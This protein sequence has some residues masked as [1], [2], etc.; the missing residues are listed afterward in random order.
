MPRMTVPAG[1]SSPRSGI[2]N[3]PNDGP[4]VLDRRLDEVHRGRSDEGGD[5]D[6]LRAVVE[7]LRRVDL[8]EKAVAHDG[9]PLAERH[10]LDL[11]VRHVHRRHVEPL[12]QPGQLGP[13]PDPQLGV[14][15]G[16]RL[17]HQECGR[18]AHDRAPHRH[19][20]ALP[21]RERARAALEQVLEPEQLRDLVDALVD[22]VLRH[23]AHPQAV[24]EV[25]R[26]GHVRVERV[27]LED[28]RD[29]AVARREVRHFPVADEERP[30][31]DLLE[32]GHHPQKR[33]F[34]AARRPD[35]HHELA[36]G[37]LEIDVI[38][39]MDVSRVDLVDALEPDRAH[40]Q[41]PPTP[42]A[43]RR[44][45]CR[46]RDAQVPFGLA[47]SLEQGD[48]QM[49]SRALAAQWRSR[50]GRPAVTATELAKPSFL[51]E[52]VVSSGEEIEQRLAEQGLAPEEIV[53]KYCWPRYAPPAGS[54]IRADQQV[55]EPRP[56]V[57]PPDR[58]ASRGSVGDPDAGRRREELRGRVRRLRP[59]VRRG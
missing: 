24:A 44:A 5:E 3:P 27:V 26:H 15:V 59:R 20:L 42:V 21:A 57:R 6:V 49:L 33:R 23:L 25:P 45:T 11:V 40:Q 4:A 55:R 35:E 53:L 7:I 41:S 43:Y 46:D 30:G 28:H 29:V 22:H 54:G 9:D 19:P 32:P 18:L 38:H 51:V 58:D 37:D 39:R 36:G 12:V 47:R 10:R 16:E 48:G 8:L 34:P 31:G 14:E 17:V 52:I 2:S 50:S 1:G 13:H 56:A